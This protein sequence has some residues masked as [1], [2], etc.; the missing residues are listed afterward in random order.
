[1]NTRN[2]IALKI[3]KHQNLRLQTPS[4]GVDAA[5]REID[6]TPAAF[7]QRAIKQDKL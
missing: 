4:Q 5:T 7:L 6:A 1:M 2:A 3:L